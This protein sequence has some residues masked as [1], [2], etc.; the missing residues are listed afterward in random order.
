MTGRRSR[1]GTLDDVLLVGVLIVG[2][3]V[4]IAVVSAVI[5]T[6][7][8][9]VKVGLLLAIVAAVGVVVARARR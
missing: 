5:S 4:A 7:V 2:A 8:F 9:V 3:L 6:V 1:L